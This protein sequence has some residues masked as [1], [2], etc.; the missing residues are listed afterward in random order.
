[1]QKYSVIIDVQGFYYKRKFIC[2]EFAYGNISTGE[3]N[4]FIICPP[5]PWDY[6]SK[7]DKKSA[8]WLTNCYHHISWYA[9]DI[10][11]ENTGT[12]LK[13]LLEKEEIDQIYV[14]GLQ[15]FNWLKQ[16]V[17]KRIIDLEDLNCP[18]MSS[19]L[20]FESD[21]CILHYEHCA[22]QNVRNL[23][24]WYK[25]QFNSLN[26]FVTFYR[27]KGLYFMSEEEISHLP[28]EFVMACAEKDIDREWN[29]FPQDWKNNKQF[30][31]YRRC[32]EHTFW[33]RSKEG[34]LTIN[35]IL[36]K[37]CLGCNGDCNGIDVCG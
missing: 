15:K 5:V 25:Q 7:R 23:I 35:S 26:S 33:G 12:M 16:F 18:N 21:G 34:G 27:K 36:I 24:C 32:Q 13:N 4:S 19:L 9:G 22:L 28:M 3:C 11:Y 8:S 20:K 29:K 10:P 37:D 30:Q 14:K 31:T 17:Q 1:M 6:L 2:K